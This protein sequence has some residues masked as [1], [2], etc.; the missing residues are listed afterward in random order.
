MERIQFNFPERASKV[1]TEIEYKFPEKHSCSV[2]LY[3]A[4][5]RQDWPQQYPYG[6]LNLVRAVKEALL[7][8]KVE[9][10]PIAVVDEDVFKR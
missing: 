4:L 6:L 2:Q 9:N 1:T 8:S 10:I 5:L 3:N 7:R